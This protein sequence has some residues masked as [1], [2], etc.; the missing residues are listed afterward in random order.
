MLP[1]LLIIVVLA[2]VVFPGTNY[3]PKIFNIELQDVGKN[4]HFAEQIIDHGIAGE[5]VKE[6]E[7]NERSK[8]FKSKKHK[9]GKKE[10]KKEEGEGEDYQWETVV[11]VLTSEVA[12]KA[13]VAAAK[14]VCKAAVGAD[15][16]DDL[17]EKERR[18]YLNGG[19]LPSSKWHE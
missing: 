1:T 18:Y 4:N 9:A 2:P 3:V 16:S 15:Y 5:P 13:A 14:E 6:K 10:S 17:A 12:K 19:Y 8:K 11:S 7:K